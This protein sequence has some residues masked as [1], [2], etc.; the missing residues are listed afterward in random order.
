MKEAEEFLNQF[1]DEV[2]AESA[3]TSVADCQSAMIECKLRMKPVKVL[4]MEVSLIK[5]V[6]KFNAAESAEQKSKPLNLIRK[7]LSVLAGSSW[8]LDQTMIHPALLF[9]AT[10]LLESSKVESQ[11]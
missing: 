4:I 10:R 2:E 7:E 5:S 8:E 6:Q 1:A 11:A 9:A 3:Q